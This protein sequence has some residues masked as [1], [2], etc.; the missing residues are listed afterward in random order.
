MSQ[1]VIEAKDL[2]KRY[3]DLTAVDS[4]SFS[5]TR[6]ELFGFLG[7]NGAGKTTTMKMVQCVSP[8]TGGKL[9]VFG[10][11]PETSGRI[12]RKRI[13]VVPQETNLDPDLSVFD[14]LTVY[15]R[16]FDIGRDD[17]IKRAKNLLE[18]FE[19]EGKKDTIIEKLSGG[20]KR[21]LLL[22]RAL[23][24]NPD[25]LILDEP[26]IG[27]DPQARHHIW[28]KLLKLRAEGH[29][30]VLTTHY[31]DE[32]ARLCDRLV[33][34]DHA[35]ILVDGSPDA[36]VRT[37]IGMDIVETD[38]SDQVTR[39]LDSIN[40][41]Y[42]TGGEMIQVRTDKPRELADRLTEQFRE[43]RVITRPGSLEDVFLMLTGRGIRE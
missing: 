27:L 39:Y 10:D 7:P 34:M 29:T 15:A 3:R 20:M 42:G 14:N 23:M 24:N 25:L 22:A 32:A 36:L 38:K 40:I 5:V 4:I 9:R 12:I 16:F 43:I 17:A 35:K 21:R 33:I 28:E 6:G 26:T 19:L 8:R 31:L 2:T 13:G 41:S 11:D 1:Y 30:I 18:F 37:F